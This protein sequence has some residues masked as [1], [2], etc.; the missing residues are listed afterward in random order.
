LSSAARLSLM[1]G[2]LDAARATA[3]RAESRAESEDLDDVLAAIEASLVLALVADLRG[4]RQEALAAIGHAV[5]L[6]EE[7]G[8]V[9]PFLVTGSDRIVGLLRAVPVTSGNDALVKAVLERSDP[10]EQAARSSFEPEPLLEPLTE[11]E[12]AVLA[13]L[14]TM[15]SNDEIAAEFYVSVNTVKSHLKHLYRKLGVTNRREA[16]QRAREIGL[17]P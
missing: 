14:P 3:A 11:R 6:A 9:R 7:Q 5:T 15:R 17:I 10:A 16:V 2:N 8:F 12:M 1:R 4:R 13:E